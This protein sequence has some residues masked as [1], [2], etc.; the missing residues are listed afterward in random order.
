MELWQQIDFG[1]LDE[2]RAL[3]T[4]ACGAHRWVDRMLM[5]RPYGSREAL[6]AVA[7]EEWFALD[8]ADW[9]EAFAHHP[10]IGQ[11]S[12]DKVASQEQSGVSGAA[13]NVLTALAE[14]NRAYE[15]KFGYI[16]I[17]CATGKSAD[18]MLAL[19]HQRMPNDAATE[20]RIA[21]EE[22]SKITALRLS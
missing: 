5:R 11:K 12:A 18:E 15:E 14:G 16:F 8:E 22:Q 20:I 2:A 9:R 3:L 1:T 4:K 21:A 10:K 6:L 7:R 17:V 19:L 13:S